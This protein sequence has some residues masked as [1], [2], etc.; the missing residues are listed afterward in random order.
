LGYNCLYMLRKRRFFP[1]P[2]GYV[3]CS[4]NA[5]FSLTAVR[6][7]SSVKAAANP[8]NSGHDD[9]NPNQVCHYHRRTA[10]TTDHYLGYAP[11]LSAN[12][13]TNF[14]AR[15]DNVIPAFPVLAG[16]FQMLQ[17]QRWTLW[18]LCDLT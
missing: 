16:V 4:C 11:R 9:E 14:L 3:S 7:C 6:I 12:V 18:K 2:V 15:L 5:S 10:M 13:D 17:H 1:K 8:G